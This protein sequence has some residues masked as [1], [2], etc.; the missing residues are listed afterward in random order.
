[1][2]RGGG[3]N[4]AG[5]VC[6]QVALLGIT[7]LL[8]RG[9]GR[10]VVGL[11]AQAFAFMALLNLLALS[12][13]RAGLTRF[14]AVHLA[15]RDDGALRGTVRL[16]I[17]LPTG[18]ALALGVALYAAAPWLVR[19]A[20]H[21]PG[22]TLALR[23][24]AVALPAATFTD[25]ALAATQGFRT[26]RPFAFIGLVFE[27]V[28]RIGLTA[29]LL[30][31][32][33]GLEGAMI[34]LVVS[35]LAA[36]VLAAGALRRLMGGRSAPRAYNVRLLFTFSSV[37]WLSSLA[38]TGLLWADTILI[39]ALRT[40]S[41]VGIYNVA[42][43]LVTLATF[44]MAPINA[45]FAPR[46][47][48]LYQ[49]GRAGSLSDT[50][51]VATSWI[52]RLSL[53]A[54]IV[55][56]AFPDDLLSTFGKGFAAG[57]TV[58][59]VLALGKLI[60]AGTGPCG[61]MLNMAGR[62]V[63]QMLD[64]VAV[65]VINIALNVWLIPRHGI[66]G[67]AVAWA[68]ALG[69]VNLLRV[70]QVFVTMRMLPFDRG[71]GK[72]VLAGAG[73]FLAAVVVRRATDPPL[74]VILGLTVVVVGYLALILLLGLTTEDRLILRMLIGGVRGSGRTQAHS[75]GRKPGRAAQ[76]GANR[77]RGAAQSGAAG[78]VVPAPDLAGVRAGGDRPGGHYA[79][80]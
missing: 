74:E 44:V 18:G 79:P 67:A 53:P 6:S 16:G 14:V 76:S 3:L 60:D 70:R 1:M 52:L 7:L 45:A 33:L 40:S 69:L 2:A 41:E 50:Y 24:V 64:N 35:N 49:R 38:S 57:A 11:Y 37:S 15:E 17:L 26:M 39:G 34:A 27:P 10:A 42:T 56:V 5:A 9:G 12:G 80:D 61:L 13:F 78:D 19:S 77:R 73:A 65:L 8:A 20:F 43:R 72:G 51:Q 66:L 46:I 59:V 21:D 36:A 58:T 47:A 29:V 63:L 22:L 25:V 62:P 31:A 23:F 4:L 48:D 55:L 32:G 28:T 30:A 71:V 54:F 75:A 68:V